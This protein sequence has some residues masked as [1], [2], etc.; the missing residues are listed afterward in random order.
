M[1][2]MRTG[3]FRV[4]V[5]KDYCVF[6]S[7]HFI[8]FAGHRC[9]SLHGHNYRMGVSLEG[10]LDPESWFVFDFVALKQLMKRVCDE[11]DH[12]VLLPL[13]NPKLTITEGESSVAVAY[14][15]VPR[16]ALSAARL[17]AA[18]DSFEYHRRDAG[19]ISRGTGESRDRLAGAPVV[20]RARGR[21][22]RWPIRVL[23]RSRRG[24]LNPA[25]R[26]RIGL[27]LSVLGGAGHTQ[28]A[29]APPHGTVV[30]DPAVRDSINAIFVRFN[31]HW[32]ELAQV[33]TLTQMLGSGH[34]TQLEY[35]GCLIGRS[36]G[37]TVWVTSWVPARRLRQLQF[38]VTGDCTHLHHFVGSWHTHPY[39][40]DS[41]RRPPAPQGARALGCRSLDLRGRA[42]PGRPGGVGS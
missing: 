32:D 33:N 23:S 4:H 34:P 24:G 7:A 12:R 8:T 11:I 29:A 42:R 36:H 26:L 22:D 5:T 38:A 15:G 6:A 28:S 17:R 27:A 41:R 39:R 31:V 18:S 1:T 21:G 40:G 9:E 37:D 20:D 10:A 25:L 3:A 35:M 19:R 13:T 2:A 14:D 30:L 16:Y